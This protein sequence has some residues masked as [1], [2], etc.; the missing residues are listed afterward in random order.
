MLEFNLLQK[1]PKKIHHLS[2]IK[3]ALSFIQTIH[4]LFKIIQNSVYTH[5]KS[6]FH[7]LFPSFYPFTD[8]QKHFSLHHVHLRKATQGL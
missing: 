3:L 6:S 1:L 5:P 8:L 7:V 4:I 2:F